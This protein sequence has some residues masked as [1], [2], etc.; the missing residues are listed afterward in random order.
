MLIALIAG[1]AVGFAWTMF[2]AL[3]RP[4]AADGTAD[5]R[6]EAAKLRKVRQSPRFYHTSMNVHPFADDPRNR[7]NRSSSETTDEMIPE[8]PEAEMSAPNPI[9]TMS[10]F[11]PVRPMRPVDR[12]D[13]PMADDEDETSGAKSGWGWLADDIAANRGPVKDGAEKP[14]NERVEKDDDDPEKK[15]RDAARKSDDERRE[16]RQREDRAYFKDDAYGS[17]AEKKADPYMRPVLADQDEK[18]RERGEELDEYG[19][20]RAESE[21][22]RRDTTLDD[23]KD[24]MQVRDPFAAGR[25]SSTLFGSRESGFGSADSMRGAG[26]SEGEVRR[27][28]TFGF[29]DDQSARV[30]RDAESS[31]RISAYSSDSVFNNG[32]GYTPQ[33]VSAYGADSAFSGSG[34]FGGFGSTPGSAADS[35]A[36]SFTPLATPNIQSFDAQRNAQEALPTPR[37]LPW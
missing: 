35:G 18:T 2:R 9:D 24:P 26:W 7:P 1:I 3:Y 33:G 23:R 20:A 32:A 13:D 30:M 37:A 6:E 11:R 29:Q 22:N 28:S 5:P 36:S 15:E 17:R 31:A 8:I 4:K 16:E 19:D 12:S 27:E 21:Q 34:A 25:E 10:N 14:K